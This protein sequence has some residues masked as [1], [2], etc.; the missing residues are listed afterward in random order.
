[1]EVDQNIIVAVCG[2][3]VLY[4]T[5][6]VSVQGQEQNREGVGR[7]GRGYWR[8]CGRMSQEV[9][10]TQGQP[11]SPALAEA[12]PHQQGGQSLTAAVGCCSAEEVVEHTGG[13]DASLRQLRTDLDDP[14]VDPP[15]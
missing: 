12:T 9:E 2:R 15:L 14:P 6:M 8:S 11:L 3:P 13:L 4:D 1:M 10:V 5:T 7:R